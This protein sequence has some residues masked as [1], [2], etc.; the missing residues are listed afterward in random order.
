M[1]CLCHTTKCRFIPLFEFIPGA[2]GIHQL[3]GEVPEEFIL[4]AHNL[5]TSFQYI[6]FIDNRDNAFSWLPF[7][8][9]LICPIYLNFEKVFLDY[10]NPFSPVLMNADEL[11]DADSSFDELSGDSIIVYDSVKFYTVRSSVYGNGIGHT[12]VPGWYQA[13]GIPRCPKTNRIMKFLCQLNRQANVPAKYHNVIPEESYH[14]QYFEE[15]NF[16]MDGDLYIFFEP[17]SKTCC[18]IIQNT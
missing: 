3:G 15:M 11:S 9:H 5:V 18:Y 8:V 16:W 10:S 7:K 14:L 2:A 13:P 12:G 17:E 6:G 4:P 1:K